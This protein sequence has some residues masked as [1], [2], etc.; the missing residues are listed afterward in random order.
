MCSWIFQAVP[1]VSVTVE[2]SVQKISGQ[3]LSLERFEQSWILI[4]LISFLINLG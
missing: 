3:F 1:S 2:I 4:T